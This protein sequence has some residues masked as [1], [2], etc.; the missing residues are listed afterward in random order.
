MKHR[1]DIKKSTTIILQSGRLLFQLYTIALS[2]LFSI[3]LLFP[4]FA[5]A[6]QDKVT[7]YDDWE[8]V[9]SSNEKEQTKDILS[10]EL[11]AEAN[12][13]I[14][15]NLKPLCK[16]TQI[17]AAKDTGQTVFAITVLPAAQTGQFVAVVSAPL[18]GYLV[19]GLEMSVD[20]RKPY[21]ILFETCNAVGC[22]AGFELKGRINS[23]LSVGKIARFKLWTTKSRPAEVS[24]SLAGFGRA[25]S[26]LKAP[27]Q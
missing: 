15:P 14:S 25:L 27:L 23:D 16:A 8:V 19:P 1:F 3:H 21:K 17:L 18:G 11:N 7:R 13:K 2:V 24:I 10:P 22:H 12:L 26:A 5:N 4:S 6:S 9:C 20:K